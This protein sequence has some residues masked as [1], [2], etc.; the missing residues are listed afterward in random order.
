MPFIN[1]AVVPEFASSLLVPRLL[2]RA[3]A[4]EMLLLGEPFGAERARE[5]GLINAIV[6]AAELA[7]VVAGKAKTLAAKP[8]GALRD[9]KALMNA[10]AA[11]IRAHIVTE[12]KIFGE[13]LK[14][15]EFKEAATA[16]FEKRAPDFSRF[17]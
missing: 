4:S 12:A 2:G 1:L 3:Q 14:S 5:I 10:G 11:E 9:A 17:N 6:P 16:F 13:R 8:P 15:P 7:A